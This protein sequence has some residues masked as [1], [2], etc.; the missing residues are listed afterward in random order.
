MQ[1]DDAGHSWHDKGPSKSMETE[2]NDREILFSDSDVEN[3]IDEDKE[4]KHIIDTLAEE[5]IETLAEETVSRYY[6]LETNEEREEA[7]CR[8]PHLESAH[9]LSKILSSDVE[10]G[11]EEDNLILAKLRALNQLK[12]TLCE[13]T[14]MSMEEYRLRNKEEFDAEQYTKSVLKQLQHPVSVTKVHLYLVT[15]MYLYLLQHLTQHCPTQMALTK[16][17]LQESS[18]IQLSQMA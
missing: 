2:M 16:S 1:N 6:A 17:R 11:D 7:Q 13:S 4:L 3:E 14:P 18:R 5:I 9:K 15:A 10:S 8:N 12:E